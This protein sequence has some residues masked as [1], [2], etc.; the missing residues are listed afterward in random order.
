MKTILITGTTGLVGRTL[1]ELFREEGHHRI[2]GTSRSGGDC[3]DYTV[4]LTSRSSVLGLSQIFQPDVIVHTAAM[5]K[6]D[7]CEKNRQDCFNVNVGA[8]ENLISVFSD[9]KIIFFSTYAVYNTPQGN[10]DE[11]CDI[12]A[13]NHYISTKLEAESIVRASPDHIILRPS[14]I[15]GYMAYSRESNNYFMQLL[16][17]IRNNRVTRSPTDQFFNPIHVNVLAYIVQLAVRKNITGLYNVGSNENISKYEFNRL[18]MKRY[19][20]DTLLLEG[21]SSADLAVKRPSNGTVS[22]KKIQNALM[23]DIPLLETMIDNLYVSSKGRIGF[24]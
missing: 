14:V 4:D 9:S 1:Y 6:T 5:T 21:I 12:L 17:N 24:S 7:I 3:V 18:V 15:F 20:F 16:D 11:E 2:F 8:T 19:G 22:S 13:T 23:Y 10:C